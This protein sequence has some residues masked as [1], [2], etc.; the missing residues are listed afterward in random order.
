MKIT[1]MIS[2]QV[3]GRNAAQV[4]GHA[5]PLKFPVLWKATQISL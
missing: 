2:V 5:K 3:G 4:K 1:M